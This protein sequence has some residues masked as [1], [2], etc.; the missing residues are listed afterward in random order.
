MIAN[1]LAY[2]DTLELPESVKD[3]LKVVT[4]GGIENP[5]DG[6]L[7]QRLAWLRFL[8]GDPIPILDLS[9]EPGMAVDTGITS[10]TIGFKYDPVVYAPP[11][12]GGATCWRSST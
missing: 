10:T 7:W 6:G 8:L 3:R 9:F 5:P 11:A 2:L 4:I 1:T 12:T